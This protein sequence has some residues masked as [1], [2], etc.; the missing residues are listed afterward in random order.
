MKYEKITKKILNELG[1]PIK[2]SGYNYILCSIDFISND[3]N[4]INEVCKI[5]YV[6]IAK[7]YLTSTLCVERNIRYVIDVIWK[8]KE[9][10]KGMIIKIFGQ[11]YFDKKPTNKV[12]LQTMYNYVKNIDMLIFIDLLEY[13]CP[14]YNEECYVLKQLINYFLK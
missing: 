9:T 14:F 13:K 5:L 4:I 6:D 10:H 7:K 3:E 12:F 8:N 1:V 11:S 2:Y